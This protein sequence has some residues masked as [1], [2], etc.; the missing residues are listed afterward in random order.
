VGLDFAESS[1][2]AAS[3]N[4]VYA[5]QYDIYGFLGQE[6]PPVYSVLNY[7]ESTNFKLRYFPA[8]V[9]KT[10]LENYA[11]ESASYLA[12][13]SDYDALATAYDTAYTAWAKYKALN[14][15]S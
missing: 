3:K 13:K 15:F 12:L 11:A 7:D 2:S 4:L 1:Y 14:V 5:K 6:Y 9:A 10:S 8:N